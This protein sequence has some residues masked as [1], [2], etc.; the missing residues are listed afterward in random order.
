MRHE[1]A[2][3]EALT[4]KGGKSA[5]PPDFSGHWVNE[6]K[7]SMDLRINGGSVSG[8]YTSKVSIGGGEISGPIIG[9][10]VGDVIAFSVL[11]PAP[12]ASIT[13][14]VGQIIAENGSQKLDT[15]WHLIVNVPNAQDPNS[16]WT[17][18]HA[19]ADIFH[20]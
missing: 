2:L 9:Y 12:T 4:A 14:W 10:V 5:T 7:S 16:I 3:T 17:T 13:S 11:W 6:L 8:T 18:I 15:L 19:G 20:R 1:K